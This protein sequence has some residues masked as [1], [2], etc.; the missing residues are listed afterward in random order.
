MRV[1][2]ILAIVV[3][4]ASGV[5]PA[6]TAAAQSQP[7]LDALAG[8]L[9]QEL[10]A[11]KG[12]ASPGPPPPILLKSRHETRRF[13]EQEMDRR[14]SAARVEQEGKALVAWGL[15]AAHYDPRG[16]CVHLTLEQVEV[17]PE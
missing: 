14:Y 10:A 16:L 5:I 12:I 4:A 13:I 1:V 15:S 7:S 8:P 3:L 2:R 11:L 6:G 9:Y 17:Q